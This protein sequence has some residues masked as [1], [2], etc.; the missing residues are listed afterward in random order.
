M[1]FIDKVSGAGAEKKMPLAFE[2]KSLSLLLRSRLRFSARPA[3]QF[4][5]LF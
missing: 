1:M 2:C 3:L 4:S 5:E